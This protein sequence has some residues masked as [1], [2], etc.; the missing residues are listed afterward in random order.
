MA[1]K[2]ILD[3][4]PKDFHKMP[5]DYDFSHKGIINFIQYLGVNWKDYEKDFSLRTDAVW[6]KD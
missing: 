4:L 1:T 6:E 5:A 3:T 2:P